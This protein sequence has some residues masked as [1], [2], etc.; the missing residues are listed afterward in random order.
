MSKTPLA[1]EGE[2][3]EDEDADIGGLKGEWNKEGGFRSG[4][5]V[6]G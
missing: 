5:F 1:F 4:A 6:C 3:L 2:D